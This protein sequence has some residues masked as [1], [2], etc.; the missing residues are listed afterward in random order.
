MAESMTP[1]CKTTPLIALDQYAWFFE[2]KRIS[3][4]SVSICRMIRSTRAIATLMLSKANT[5][6]HNKNSHY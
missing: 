6:A 4:G 3:S 5:H 1:R 2:L